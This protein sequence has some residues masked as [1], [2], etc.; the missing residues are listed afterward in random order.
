MADLARIG[1]HWRP[2]QSN[3][4]A[5]SSKDLPASGLG[6]LSSANIPVQGSRDNI[7]AILT[8]YKVHGRAQCI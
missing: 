2:S 5:S 3:E 8:K 7:S 1:W 4:I 6:G